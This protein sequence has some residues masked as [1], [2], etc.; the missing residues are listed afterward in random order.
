MEIGKLKVL[1][2]TGLKALR[3]FNVFYSLMLGYRMHPKNVLMSDIDFL[4]HFSN[5]SEEEKA[6]ELI[7]AVKFVPLEESE[8]NELICFCCDSNGV[9]LSALNTK[10]MTP[11][12]IADIIVSVSLEFS[13][14]KLFTIGAEELKKN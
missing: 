2:L 13:K 6:R 14:T 8:V 1:P 11:D 5:L 7:E 10:E 4:K 9:P 3:A 12:M